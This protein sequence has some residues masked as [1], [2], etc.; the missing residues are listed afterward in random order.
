MHIA[1]ILSLF[2]ML[3]CLAGLVAVIYLFVLVVKLAHRGITALDLYIEEKRR[4]PR[5]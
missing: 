4:T 5:F 2:Y 1:G 3:F